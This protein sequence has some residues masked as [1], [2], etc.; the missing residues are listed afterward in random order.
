MWK[1]NPETFSMENA[2][3]KIDAI[4]KYTG[5]MN[6]THVEQVYYLQRR[7]MTF[8]TISLMDEMSL[9]SIIEIYDIKVED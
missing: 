9:D 8:G 5:K 7:M 1:A 2:N 3:Q 4:L 6:K